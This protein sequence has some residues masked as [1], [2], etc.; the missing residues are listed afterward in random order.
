VVEVIGSH[1]ETPPSF[2]VLVNKSVLENGKLVFKEEEVVAQH[3]ED[4]MLKGTIAGLKR[5]R[6]GLRDRE[7]MAFKLIPLYQKNDIAEAFEEW[8]NEIRNDPLYQGS[9][10]PLVCYVRTDNAGEWGITSSKWQEM[11]DTM[12]GGKVMDSRFI[13]RR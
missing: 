7:S 5:G 8:V 11:C 9:N 2:K 13:S 3:P 4:R 6:A 10:Y 1:K 12:N